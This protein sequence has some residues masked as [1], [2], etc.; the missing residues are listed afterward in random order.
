MADFLKSVSSEES[1]ANFYRVVNFRFVAVFDT[2]IGFNSID[3]LEEGDRDIVEYREGN[4]LELNHKFP[5]QQKFGDVTLVRA[6]IPKGKAAP[7]AK[8]FD[9]WQADT[10]NVTTGIGT[11][12]ESFRK[13]FKVHTYDRTVWVPDDSG[14]AATATWIVYN[15]ILKSRKFSQLDAKGNDYITETIVVSPE[16]IYKVP[17]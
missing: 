12:P 7:G 9:T 1:Y 4:E 3:G 10:F 13:T 2:Q 17:V 11:G 8:F 15:A 5:G 16:Y 14:G 6:L